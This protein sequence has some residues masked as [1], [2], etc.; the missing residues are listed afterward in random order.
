MKRVA[1]YARV[2]TDGQTVDNQLRELRATA[3]RHGWEVVAEFVDEGISGAK[4]RD[5]RPGFDTLLKAVALCQVHMVAAWSVD[6]LGRS[7]QDLVAFLEELRSKGVDL[8]LQV[9]GLD[10]STPAGRA[11]FQMLGVF[12]EFERSMIRERVMSGL[13]RARAEGKRLGRP[14]VGQDVEA[15]IKAMRGAGKGIRK[16]AS[17]LGCGVSTVQRVVGATATAS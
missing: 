3:K 7:L 15:Q 17:S 14:T 4:G 16:I 8:F 5:H 6:R 1:I 11:M 2:S 13:D 9:Q 10:T 12:S